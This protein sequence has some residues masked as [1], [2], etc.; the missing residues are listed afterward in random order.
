MRVVETRRR[1]GLTD[2]KS[3]NDVERWNGSKWD[4]VSFDVKSQTSGREEIG[5][6]AIDALTGSFDLVLRSVKMVADDSV[7]G[8]W[9]TCRLVVP[10]GSSKTTARGSITVGSGAQAVTKPSSFRIA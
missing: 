10:Q 9:A 4:S 2:G 8:G 6:T 7:A 3:Y 1:I 5:F